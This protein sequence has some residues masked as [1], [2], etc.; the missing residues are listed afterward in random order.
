MKWHKLL[1]YFLK[2]ACFL[3]PSVLA[4]GDIQS[5][6][7][8]PGWFDTGE[9]N[10]LE[11]DPAAFAVEAF[12]GATVLR[13]VNP[14][15]DTHSH[16]MGN[17]VQGLACEYSGRMYQGEPGSGIGL[18]F[19]SDYPNSNTYYKLYSIWNGYFEITSNS[20]PAKSLPGYGNTWKRPTAGSWTHFRVQWQHT[21]PV[22]YIKAK[23]W[24]E[25][26]EEPGYWQINVEDAAAN[27]PQNCRVGVWSAGSNGQSYWDQIELKHINKLEPDA[28][29]ADEGL[30]VYR[31]AWVETREENGDPLKLSEGQ[32]Y[33]TGSP[34]DQ[35]DAEII[36][37]TDSAEV[38]EHMVGSLPSYR[39]C[40]FTG[41]MRKTQ[42]SAQFGITVASGFPHQDTYYG[43]RSD[44]SDPAFHLVVHPATGKALPLG[45]MQTG[46]V[47][48]LNTR[49]QFRVQWE[50][51]D[52]STQVR[53]K[54]W[55]AEDP[56]P[57]TWQIQVEDTDPDHYTR[58]RAG[59]WSS[60][61]AEN[62]WNDLSLH[63]G[64]PRYKDFDDD[65][66]RDHVDP[67]QD[68]DSF[69]NIVEWRAGS[70]PLAKTSTP[71]TI[72]APPH[73]ELL[74]L[75]S[76]QDAGFETG[77]WHA[78]STI[79]DHLL[80]MGVYAGGSGLEPIHTGFRFVLPLSPTAGLKSAKLLLYAAGEQTGNPQF[81][82]WA[83]ASDD[84]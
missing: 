30:E 47:P 69:S 83:D 58:C 48:E 13:A 51:K 52:T 46:V 68:N 6:E 29:V 44:V 25:G 34:E 27:R 9:H 71:E 65:G 4:Y 32:F 33:V 24:L 15:Y 38:H 42:E 81:R 11:E 22:T 2:V 66:L 70:K 62:F 40:E 78:G 36:N 80:H 16:F 39:I 35:N 45:P 61:A 8:L 53:G 60:G 3:L 50:D 10:S 72:Q 28:E 75:P 57:E 1:G 21:A 19:G 56:E 63:E 74:N 23:I 20:T 37:I 31:P 59:V 55:K 79:T 82:I 18:T 43:I 41:D 54:V 5:V 64:D 49:Y 17:Q 14:A 84:C 12:Q 26:Q 76:T 7:E 73:T 77:I 67:D